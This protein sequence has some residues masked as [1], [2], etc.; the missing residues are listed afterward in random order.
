MAW[1]DHGS[2]A[3]PVRV[4]VVGTQLAGPSSRAHRHTL[5]YFAFVLLFPLHAPVLEPNFD[6]AFGQTQGMGYLYASSSGQV[7]VEVEF[8]LELQRLVS[9]I[10]L[11]A[12]LAL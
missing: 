11:A 8:L 12:S 1:T 9:S 10:R 6:L 2:Y 4:L 7:A 5:L 3:R